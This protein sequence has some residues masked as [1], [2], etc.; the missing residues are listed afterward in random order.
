MKKAMWAFWVICFSLV[1]MFI[2]GCSDDDDDPAVLDQTPAAFSFTSQ[3][4]VPQT[5]LI[6]SDTIT[7]TGLSAAATAPISV[8]A[9][10]AYAINSGAYVTTD[11][12]VVNGD[13]VT[14]QHTSAATEA[15]AMVTT[16][17]I[18]GVTGTFTSTTATTTFTFSFPPQT[19]VAPTT[20]ITSDTITIAGLTAP[21][22]ISISPGSTYSI[23]GG[24]FTD[25]AGTIDNGQTV[26]VQHTSAATEATATV[27]TLSIGAVTGTFTSTTA[28]TTFTFGF[29]PQ[30]GVAPTTL[31][32]SDTI[33]I[34][35]LTAPAAISV[36]AGSA[37]SLNGGA[38][39]TTD[40][41][42][43]NGDTV[44]VQHTSSATQSTDT[45]T[46]L[47]ISGVTGTFTSTTLA[48]AAG[49]LVYDTNCASCHMLGTYDAA[50]FAGD[51]AGAGAQLS[52][53]N[54]Y[55]TPDVAGHQ[56]ITLSATQI[57]DLTTYLNSF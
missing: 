7:I 48:P 3:D 17:T 23:N 41:T 39:V 49:Q 31:L 54:R 34:A 56:G 2:A 19:S 8:S 1:I 6:T 38:Y 12:T 15:S 18:G 22:A 55:P 14:V 36:S 20:L 47:T 40:G 13:T 5:T 28:S 24:A 26:A 46:T 44:T 21:A 9:G 27:T 16:L 45:I 25:V 43:V 30:T 57:A 35:G 50:G 33:T 4:G 42:V 32:T 52:N 29:Q 37:Y 51:L 10:S 53:A 11:G